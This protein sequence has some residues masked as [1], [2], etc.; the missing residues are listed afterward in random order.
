MAFRY[1][2]GG[3]DRRTHDWEEQAKL[4]EEANGEI[5]TTLRELEAKFRQLLQGGTI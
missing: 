4:W 3:N 1:K 2:V 5:A